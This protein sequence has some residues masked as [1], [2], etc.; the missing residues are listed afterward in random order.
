MYAYGV[1]SAPRRRPI[2]PYYMYTAQFPEEAD[3]LSLH[4]IYCI[5]VDGGVQR[6]RIMCDAERQVSRDGLQNFPILAVS[7]APIFAVASESTQ[8]R[9]IQSSDSRFA[10]LDLASTMH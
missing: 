6:S 10:L 7:A 2:Q 4:S 9:S 5:W 8:Y 3:A 1:T